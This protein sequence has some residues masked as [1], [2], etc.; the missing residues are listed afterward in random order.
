M[1][2]GTACIPTATPDA[3]Q[4]REALHLLGTA[5]L[6]CPGCSAECTELCKHHHRGCNTHCSRSKPSRASPGPV[7]SPKAPLSAGR[8]LASNWCQ[9]SPPQRHW[10][11][12]TAGPAGRA[13]IALS[14][15]SCMHPQGTILDPLSLHS[16]NTHHTDPCVQP[17]TRLVCMLAGTPMQQVHSIVHFLR[18]KLQT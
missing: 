15:C 10:G 14:P 6:C 18:D 9:P 8:L 16:S 13:P 2:Q 11:Y 12:N 5:V 1:D 4:N 17:N 3:E 7:H